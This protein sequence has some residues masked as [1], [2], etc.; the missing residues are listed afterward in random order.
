LSAERQRGWNGK[1]P[2]LEPPRCE[3]VKGSKGI[4]L[5]V[6]EKKAVC[7]RRRHLTE[8]K[9]GAKTPSEGEIW[10]RTE[11]SFFRGKKKGGGLEFLRVGS[12]GC[13]SCSR[14]KGVFSWGGSCTSG[15]AV[16]VEGN[17]SWGGACTVLDSWVRGLRR[18]TGGD[19]V[20]GGA[21]SSILREGG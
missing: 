1:K 10:F 18:G 7:A 19:G 9:R 5:R 2:K 17:F 3:M 14:W 15:G 4:C 13:S 20:L 11:R 8:M 6:G 12:G 21:D 16:V